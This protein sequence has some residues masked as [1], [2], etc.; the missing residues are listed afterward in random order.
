MDTNTILDVILVL[1]VTYV[2]FTGIMIL[3]DLTDITD[4]IRM[5]NRKLDK[6]V[7]SLSLNKDEEKD[8]KLILPKCKKC[9]GV[10]VIFNEGNNKYRI[11]CSC[12][13]S[14]H[15]STSKK[16]IIDWWKNQN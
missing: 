7:E 12:C 10:A 8:E 13:N 1:S 16:E 15:I 9:G 5:T 3:H 6:I 2:V 14:Q 4:M 11:R